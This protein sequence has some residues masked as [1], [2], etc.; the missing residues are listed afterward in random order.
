MAVS[1]EGV[2]V[3]LP[4]QAGFVRRHTLFVFFLL[5]FALTWPLQIV[6]ALGSHG[7]L[8]FRVPVVAQIFLVAYMPTLAAIITSALLGGPAAVRQLLRKLLIWRVEGRWYAVAI[9]TFALLCGVAIAIANWVGHGS[10]LP[11]VSA[12]V[13]GAGWLAVLMLPALFLVTTIVNGEEL[14][15]RGFA[16]P[17]LQTHSSALRAS[18]FLGVIWILFHL[19]LWLTFRG[20][21]F[22]PLGMLSWSIQLMAASIIFTW[23][24]NHTRGSVL[25]AYLLHGSI[26]TWTRVFPID[27]APP[28]AGWLLTAGVCLVA[29]AVVAGFGA[30]NLR[31]EGPRITD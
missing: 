13:A 27:T 23:L 30:E 31:R 7:L 3:V 28:L 20:H 9:L 8:N 29:I 16:L 25:L 17:R 22:S 18:L 1:N 10:M 24:Y 26:N 5:V 19:P 4:S 12:E 21:P 14:A 2:D 11:L 15:W 6:D